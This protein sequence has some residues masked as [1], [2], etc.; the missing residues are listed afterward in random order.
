MTILQQAAQ[1]LQQQLPSQQVL[2]QVA[3]V[4]GSGLGAATQGFSTQ[5]R[6]AYA[7]IP[8][9]PRHDNANVQGHK[10]EL[11]LA[12]SPSGQWVWLLQGRVHFYEGFTPQQVVFPI[13]L[14]KA[15]GVKN[16]LL[17]NAAGGINPQY[18]VGDLMLITDHLN[19][20][21]QN[22]LIGQNDDALGPR[23]LDMTEAYDLSW[24]QKAMRTANSIGVKLQQGVYAG[25]LGPSY[26]T[27]A[28]IKM[29][30][31]LGADAVGMSTV[32]ETIAAR[33]V[34]LNVLGL[35]M[36]SNMAAGLSHQTLSHEEVLT[37]GKQSAEVLGKLLVQLIP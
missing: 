37:V 28:E 30:A 3:V 24:R 32:M 11:A 34:G 12:Q 26:E 1:W 18:S 5:A 17:T 19:L 10:G 4:L 21:G 29:L 22:P 15:L 35:S 33:H 20:T 36:I 31:F 9:F 27:P 16:L 25:L 2:P 14:L 8:N 13:R 7:E 23:F 6:F